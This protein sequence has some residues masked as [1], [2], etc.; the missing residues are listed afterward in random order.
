MTDPEPLGWYPDGEG[1]WRAAP[2][3]I[4]RATGTLPFVT[5]YLLVP[6]ADGAAI[7]VRLTSDA[8][9]LRAQ[10]QLADTCYE[11]TAVQDEVDL[12]VRPA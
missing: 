7:G 10:V 1:G 2:T 8:F 6:R 12:V 11:L 5:G 9:E 3:V 4:V